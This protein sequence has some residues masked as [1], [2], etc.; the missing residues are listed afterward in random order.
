MS[1][2]RQ[3]WALAGCPL[4][5]FILLCCI[6]Y[7]LHWAAAMRSLL[8][9]NASHNFYLCF[10]FSIYDTIFSIYV[11]FFHFFSSFLLYCICFASF[12]PIN[13]WINC[14]GLHS[15]FHWH[16]APHQLCILIIIIGYQEGMNSRVL[17]QRLRKF[18][19]C[20]EW[21]ERVNPIIL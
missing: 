4:N 8:L 10:L 13:E 1:W 18:K 11:N 7:L 14:E 20:S 21:R 3:R 9:P 16:M 2:N 6:A 19:R 5:T 17:D 12:V 15:V